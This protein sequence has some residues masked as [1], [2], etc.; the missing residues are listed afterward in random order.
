MLL[1]ISPNYVSASICASPTLEYGTAGAG[2][3]SAWTSSF[4]A[5]VAF[6]EEDRNGILKPYAVF[7]TGTRKL[8]EYRHLQT[9]KDTDQWRAGNSKD[10][11]RL[12]QDRKN[13]PEQGTNTTI[14]KHPRDIS[15]GRKT[16]YLRVVVAYKPTNSC[17]HLRSF[18]VS[19]ILL[20]IF[21]ICVLQP[22]F[23]GIH[24][25]GKCCGFVS[26]LLNAF[27]T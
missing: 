1:K 27:E 10:I 18:G 2:C 17:T 12:C 21:A 24:W 6:F 13:S 14:F 7:N 15:P 5:M 19:G 3:L 16:I 22:Y 23:G 8:E 4:A 25:C 20:D 26:N 9:G 11:T